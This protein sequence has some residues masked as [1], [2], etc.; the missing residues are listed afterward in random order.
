MASELSPD[1][2]DAVTV[3]PDIQN[4]DGSTDKRNSS[5]FRNTKETPQQMTDG[6]ATPEEAVVIPQLDTSLP[7]NWPTRKK[8]LNIAVPSFISFVVWVLPNFFADLR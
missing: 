5:I 8:F 3:V 1:H 2:H 7:L 6:S 4:E